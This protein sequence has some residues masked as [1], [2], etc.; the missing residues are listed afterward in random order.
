MTRMQK[1]TTLITASILFGASLTFYFL[2]TCGLPGVSNDSLFYFES[3]DFIL[4]G[5]GY[6]TKIWGVIKPASHYPPL[7]PAALAGIKSLTGSD[8]FKATLWLN[9]IMW[10]ASVAGLFFHF[11]QVTQSIAFAA[12]ASCFCLLQHDVLWVHYMAWS[13]GIFIC[14]MI[15]GLLFLHRY[16]NS[17]KLV[18]GLL[19]GLIL[20]LA[21]L[22]RYSGMVFLPV[23]SLC[24]V[25]GEGTLK[26][27]IGKGWLPLFVFSV[28]VSGWLIRNFWVLGGILT[29]E[30][31]LFDDGIPENFIP[32]TMKTL[33]GWI[34]MDHN[35]NH[36]MVGWIVCCIVLALAVS[37]I[38]RN[39]KSPRAATWYSLFLMGYG[40]LLW[41]SVKFFDKLAIGDQRILAPA[42]LALMVVLCFLI[43]DQRIRILSGKWLMLMLFLPLIVWM[44][45]EMKQTRTLLNHFS[46]TG[47]EFTD[48]GPGDPRLILADTIRNLKDG[49]P[50]LALEN[51]DHYL[52]FLS[53]KPIGYVNDIYEMTYGQEL[54][55]AYYNRRTTLPN[56]GFTYLQVQSVIPGYLYKVMIK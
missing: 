37:D 52:Q 6:L 17:R 26:E 51:E 3:A 36:Q 23:L 9:G 20:G 27:R 43:W 13:E 8:Y 44:Y 18:P 34:G 41:L 55:F 31:T 1:A 5:K 54:Y 46:E 7:F 24:M 49:L 11:K 40:V 56:L 35:G 19:A 12:A 10:S 38:V 22:T 28:M 16:V 30:N 15:W 32:T 39:R 45:Q 47:S 21:A 42:N 50:V 4:A 14:C 2:H 25:M 53:G 33:S 48:I 29:R